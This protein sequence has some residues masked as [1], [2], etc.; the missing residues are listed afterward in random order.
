MI[1]ELWQC[2]KCKTVKVI[3]IDEGYISCEECGRTMKLI[4]QVNEAVK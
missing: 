3:P 2:P 4:C 1:T